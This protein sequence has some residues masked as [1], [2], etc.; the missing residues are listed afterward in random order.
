MNK[1]QS[2]GLT[3]ANAGRAFSFP[4]SRKETSN[5]VKGKTVGKMIKTKKA[6]KK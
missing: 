1:V 3:Q 2:K 6:G 4:A 5:I